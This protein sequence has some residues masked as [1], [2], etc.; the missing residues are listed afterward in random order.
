M[1]G[2]G[3]EGVPLIVKDDVDRVRR[4]HKMDE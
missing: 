3:S 1:R 2:G 4:K